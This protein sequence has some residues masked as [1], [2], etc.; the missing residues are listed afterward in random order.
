MTDEM[1][2]ICKALVE[3]AEHLDYCGYG[4]RWESMCARE[5]GMI[6]RIDAAKTQAKALLKARRKTDAA[7]RAKRGQL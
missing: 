4:D 7:G 5:S 6:A 2:A 3:A 1:R